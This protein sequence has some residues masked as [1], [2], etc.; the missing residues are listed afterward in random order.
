MLVHSPTSEGER[1]N[2][3]LIDTSKKVIAFQLVDSTLQEQTVP[4][5]AFQVFIIEKILANTL[6]FLG[7]YGYYG[8]CASL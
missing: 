1:S 6:Q 8:L 2:L 4:D 3:K 7:N 5:V